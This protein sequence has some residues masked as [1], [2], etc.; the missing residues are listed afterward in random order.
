[1]KKVLASL[2]VALF[3]ALP[4]LSEEKDKKAGFDP[5]KMVGAW[6]ITSGERGGDKVDKE[7]LMAKITITKDTIT[8]P[9]GPD[10]KFVIAYK[11]DNKAN[12]AKIDME[13]KDGPG[14]G[15]KAI[16]ILS[17]EG[18]GFKL[19]YVQQEDDNAKRPEKFESTKA[20]NAFLFVLKPDKK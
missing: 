3:V 14:T 6:A 17:W 10:Q 8:I 7:R 19:C 4:A 12:P 11:V 9:A 13:I 5:A 2:A 1:M 18:D 16:G 20:N 15:G